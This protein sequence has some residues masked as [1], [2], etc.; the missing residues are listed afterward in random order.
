VK[1]L[2]QPGHRYVST[3]VRFST[4]AALVGGR[5]RVHS[6][7]QC[8]HA[9]MTPAIHFVASAGTNNIRK[10]V[11]FLSGAIYATINS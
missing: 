1:L 8:P 6:E 11:F 9:Q 10:F 2:F 4:E 3:N 7:A 5:R